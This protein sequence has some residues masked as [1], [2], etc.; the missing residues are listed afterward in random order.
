MDVCCV[1]EGLMRG[2]FIELDVTTPRNGWQVMC[3]RY[4][5]VRGDKALAYKVGKCHYPQ[6]N[7]SKA[8]AEHLLKRLPSHFDGCEVRGLSLAYFPQNPDD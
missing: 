8:V 6:C 5:I 1:G 7:T 3:D 2:E 4:W